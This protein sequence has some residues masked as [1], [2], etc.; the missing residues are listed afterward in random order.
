MEHAQSFEALQI[1]CVWSFNFIFIATQMTQAQVRFIN[2]L[3]LGI[4]LM[5]FVFLLKCQFPFINDFETF[6]E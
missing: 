6:V 2:T 4:V 3:L 1:K 5:R